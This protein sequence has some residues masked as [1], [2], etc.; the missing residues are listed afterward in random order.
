MFTSCKK[1]L[2][3][4][5]EFLS[6]TTCVCWSPC[7]HGSGYL[8]VTCRAFV[9]LNHHLSSMSA[10]EDASRW[11]HSPPKWRSGGA[12]REITCTTLHRKSMMKQEREPTLPTSCPIPSPRERT[13]LLSLWGVRSH[14]PPFAHLQVYFQ[15]TPLHG[16]SPTPVQL[17]FSSE[18]KGLL[19]PDRNQN[20]E[21]RQ[22]GPGKE[23]NNVKKWLCRN[24]RKIFDLE[25]L[26][27]KEL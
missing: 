15:G 19:D 23:R 14:L 13:M 1:L 20:G 26:G 25:V 18:N 21:A 16:L 2:Y 3:P 9:A 5:T 6:P 27:E 22:S 4:C 12:G 10:K 7:V 24:C 11:L 17:I 8:F